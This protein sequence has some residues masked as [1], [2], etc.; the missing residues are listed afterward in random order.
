MLTPFR[1]S[2]VHRTPHGDITYYESDPL[3]PP[4][5]D[6]QDAPDAHAPDIPGSPEAAFILANPILAR[7]VIDTIG[8]V[9]DS[10]P[11]HLLRRIV[12]AKFQQTAMRLAHE[13]TIELIALAQARGEC[14][15]LLLL[16][17]DIGGILA[18]EKQIRSAEDRG[19]AEE[20]RKRQSDFLER[21]LRSDRKGNVS[22][23][24]APTD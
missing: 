24:S 1:P 9:W 2:F 10:P 12:A 15:G 17:Q 18:L 5:L 16:I 19:K 11:W 13:E 6:G 14:R 20:I 3:M 4:K 23:G 7:E 22:S 21:F 8:P